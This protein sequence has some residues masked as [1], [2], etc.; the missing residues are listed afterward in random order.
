MLILLNPNKVITIQLI[1]SRLNQQTYLEV[2]TLDLHLQI[3]LLF[4][5]FKLLI[6]AFDMSNIDH[7]NL[8]AFHYKNGYK[9]SW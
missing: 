5:D 4:N 2:G 3:K 1:I 8:I 7:L 6:L 9:I